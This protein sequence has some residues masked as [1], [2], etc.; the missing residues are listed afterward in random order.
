VIEDGKLFTKENVV[1]IYDSNDAQ[2]IIEIVHKDLGYYR[3]LVTKEAVKKR[4]IVARDV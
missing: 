1:V 4:Y 2:K 3:K